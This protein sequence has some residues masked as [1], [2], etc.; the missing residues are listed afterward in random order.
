[1]SAGDIVATLAA[2]REQ[3]STA[4]RRIHAAV[5]T[6]TTHHQTL[7]GL[8]HGAHHPGAR[9][10]TARLQAAADRLREAHQASVAAERAV[11][12]YQAVVT[13]DTTILLAGS[14]GSLP[15]SPIQ[16]T[17]PTSASSDNAGALADAAP[18]WIQEVAD[19]LPRRP[20]NKG[21][22]HGVITDATG[23][24]L[25]GPPLAQGGG[26]LRSGVAPGARDGIRADWHS[27]AQVTSE[28]VEAHAAALLR[29]P[30][31]PRS[32]TLIVNNNPC[33]SRGQYVGCDELLPGMLPPGTELTVY[34]TDG[35]HTRLVKVY[36]GTG[37][38]LI[39]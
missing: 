38:G 17:T 10:V 34:V 24:S 31:A 14:P 39:P 9:A 1:M 12:A 19:R 2:I 27:L 6:T 22:T 15:I 16:A 36:T 37:E 5:Q 26:Q 25:H 11:A 30:G 29:Q 4:G 35:Q 7:N 21:P 33:V 13:G 3:V 20:R 28:H 32:A 23:A 18:A 8:L